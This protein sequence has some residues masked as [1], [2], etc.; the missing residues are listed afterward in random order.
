MTEKEQNRKEKESLGIDE[1]A[2]GS[3]KRYRAEGEYQEGGIGIAGPSRAMRGKSERA[4][5]AQPTRQQ[6][7]ALAICGHALRYC[8]TF[9]DSFALSFVSVVWRD[10]I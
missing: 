10:H 9:P 3:M 4:I 5:H 7:R 1:A 8:C 6:K 2:V